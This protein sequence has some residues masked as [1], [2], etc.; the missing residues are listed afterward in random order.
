MY[1]IL[2]SFFKQ[3]ELF[4]FTLGAHNLVAQFLSFVDF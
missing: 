3:I 2:K 4:Q 1:E